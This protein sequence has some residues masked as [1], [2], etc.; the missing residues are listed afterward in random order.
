MVTEGEKCPTPRKTGGGIVREGIMSGGICP[1]Y[2]QGK[3]PDPD[4]ITGVYLHLEANVIK[5][6]RLL[7]R[8]LITC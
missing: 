5:R 1:G 4:E 2:I 7:L 8:K 3:C 6:F